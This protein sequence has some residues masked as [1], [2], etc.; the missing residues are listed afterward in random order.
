MKSS[1]SDFKI[2][3]PCL[4]LVFSNIEQIKYHL[5]FLNLY[6]LF[7]SVLTGPSLCKTKNLDIIFEQNGTKIVRVECLLRFLPLLVLL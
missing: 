4:D 2:F 1:H 3:F 6:Q 7:S 5:Y